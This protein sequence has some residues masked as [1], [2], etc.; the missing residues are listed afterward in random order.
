[1]IHDLLLGKVFIGLRSL[2]WSFW[3]WVL[4][5]RFA[6]LIDWHLE[7]VTFLGIYVVLRLERSRTLILLGSV[8]SRRSWS[9][10]NL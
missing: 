5:V 2:V 8:D 9:A 7:P 6:A 3:L 4:I 1:L 10:A